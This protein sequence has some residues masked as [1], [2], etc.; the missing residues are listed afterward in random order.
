M[1]SK[2]ATRDSPLTTTRV[3]GP[4]EV[5]TKE[6][7]VVLSEVCTFALLSQAWKQTQCLRPW[8]NNVPLTLM[9]MRLARQGPEVGGRHQARNVS[10][11][12]GASQPKPR[13]TGDS[14]RLIG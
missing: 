9:R 3:E 5:A 4:S 8:R 11:S 7:R 10:F 13:A 1:N 12:S 2:Q 6:A 14:K